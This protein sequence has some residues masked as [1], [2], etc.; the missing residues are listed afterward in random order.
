MLLFAHISDHIKCWWIIFFG[1][2]R[3]ENFE[4]IFCCLAFWRVNRKAF[5]ATFWNPS[6]QLRLS[7]PNK[8]PRKMVKKSASGDVYC[9]F[10]STFYYSLNHK[11]W[12]NRIIKRLM[13][14]STRSLRDVSAEKLISL[15]HRHSLLW[16]SLL[17]R[18]HDDHQVTTQ[19]WGECVFLL[20]S[21]EREEKQKSLN[22][23]SLRLC[24]IQ[25]LFRVRFMCT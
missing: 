12:N 7:R 9:L 5:S 1:V 22:Y 19:N 21:R 23:S 20:A 15:G 8:D 18:C 2:N 14:D 11:K 4:A 17:I 3:N 6:R 25:A 16:E 10:V 13:K 24:D